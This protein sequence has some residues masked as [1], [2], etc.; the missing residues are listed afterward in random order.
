MFNSS[1][2]SGKAG[3]ADSAR[4]HILSALVQ[5]LEQSPA[6][7]SS[8]P[9]V[10]DHA[11]LYQIGKG[12]HG[13]V[14]LAR[15]T[16]GT[17]RAVKI[18]YRASFSDEQR[19]Y[20]REFEG[21]LKYE[22]LSRTHEGLM[23][24]LH[25]GRNDAAGCFYYVMEL[26]DPVAGPSQQSE[27]AATA[28]YVPRTLRTELGRHGRLPVTDA[29]QLVTRLATALAHLHAQGLVHRDVKPSNI[30]FV[31]GQPKLADIGLVTG[32]GDSRSFV[33]T[34]GFIAPEGP[35]SAQADVYSL[36]KLLYELVTGRDRMEF[37]RLPADLAR[38]PDRE[39]ILDLNEVITRACAVAPG[40][41]YTS[42]AQMESDLRI[43][44]AGRSLREAR[45]TEHHLVQLRWFAV[46]ASVATVLAL[47]GLWLASRA[48][49]R[50]TERAHQSAA[51]AQ[52]ELELRTRAEAAERESR[53]QLY[54]AMLEQARATVRSGEL[55]HRIRALEALHRAAGI[56]N[57]V[58]LSR[59]AIAALSL[60]DLRF[61][62]ELPVE[63]GMT[64]VQFDPA[65]ERVAVC[66][67]RGPIE[68]RSAADFRLLVSL[69][70]STNRP[71]FIGQWSTDG[72]YLA[73]KRDHDGAG[74]RAWFEVWEPA[75]AKCVLSILDGRRSGF[76]F[77]PRLPQFLAGRQGG[78][79]TLADLETGK[80]IGATTLPNSPEYIKFSPDGLRIAVAYPKAGSW[81]VVI[82][83]FADAAPLLSHVL[84][85]RIGAIDWDPDS[86][87]LAIADYAGFVRLV[88]L[89][90]GDL[91][92]LG[93]H[94]A[95]AVQA[96]F[97]PLGQYLVTGSWEREFICW[98]VRAMQRAFTMRLDSFQMHF[99]EDGQQCAVLARS[100]P[101]LRVYAFDSPAW[102]RQF[103]VGSRVHSAAFSPN[104]RWFAAHCEKSLSLWDLAADGPA[105]EIAEGAHAR[106]FFTRDGA[107]MFGSI[108]ANDCQRWRIAAAPTPNAPPQVERLEFRKPPG[109]TSL[110]LLPNQ[111]VWTTAKG[112]RLSSFEDPPSD[113]EGWIPTFSGITGA[114]PDNR[115]LGINRPFDP[116]LH[117]YRLP[118]LEQVAKL[119]HLANIIAFR[120]SPD[121]EEVTVASRQHVQF[122]STRNWQTTRTLTNFNNILYMPDG[123]GVWLSGPFAAAGLYDRKTLQPQLLLP[124]EMV[125]LAISSDSRHLAVSV[126]YQFMQV[127]DVAELREHF[128]RLGIGLAARQFD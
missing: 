118:G 40:Q 105:A 47:G 46:A 32:A 5:R 123:S 64:L 44:L 30:I 110:C 124:D 70:A 42:A 65:F 83:R 35:G 63:R 14:W 119:T 87:R 108:H 27:A 12:A 106:P 66:R 73:V 117:V 80:E 92:T 38:L 57:S 125:P 116:A 75:S 88:D 115:W 61:E 68:I 126:N 96:A 127:W 76:A 39:A 41:R 6:N 51:R 52:T 72:R 9:S 25:V 56:S 29:A 31:R 107:E 78:V 53:E 10:P 81:H 104:D 48:E 43:F 71:V 60:P 120:F 85:D 67:G 94:R 101:R 113:S 90:T 37:P 2:Q 36:G 79:M 24:V 4:D 128:R 59:E 91:R 102:L 93:R 121:G 7:T 23:Q 11:L 3:S 100:A 16:P 77:H 74:Y 112:S 8:P 49:R 95:V 15:S 34:E 82:Q 103:E 55:G 122:W 86:S 111:I 98:D 58:E 1:T 20:E 22:P 69:P 21:I 45:N 54:S 62:R 89:D 109:F 50:A 84:G 18:V 13:D 114:S 28:P 26:A 17:L 19:P 33:G 97:H 99:R